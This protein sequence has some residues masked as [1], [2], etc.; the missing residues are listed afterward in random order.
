[1]FNGL[2]KA[3]I[4]FIVVIALAYPI[5]RELAARSAIR[6]GLID[7]LDA[8]DAAALRAWPGSAESFIDMLHDRCMRAH[9]GDEEACKQYA[10][11]D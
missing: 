6:H 11:A 2:I 10:M 4:A 8:N 9:G 1:M 3:G 7:M 5:S